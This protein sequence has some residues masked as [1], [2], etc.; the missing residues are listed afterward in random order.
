[1]VHSSLSS[2]GRVKGGARAV[3]EALQEAV[4][5][6]GTLMMPSFNHGA[7]YRPG[8]A[9]YYS[10]LETPTTNGAI[11]DA[12]W[13]MD[14][15]RR[16]LN[17]THAFAAWGR[18]A[19]R[20]TQHHHRTLTMGPGSPLGLLAS[21]GGYC[22]LMGVGYRANTFHHVV[23]MSTGAPCLG[24]RTE[25]YPVLL[26]D[27]RRVEG[28]TWGWRAG[29]CPITDEQRYA[30]LMEARGLERRHMV[31]G[32]ELILYRLWDCY[33]VVAGLLATGVDGFPSCSRC[34]VRPRVTEHTVPSDWDEDAGRPV[35]DSV[36]WTY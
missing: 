34:P 12:F 21:D 3:I 25:A 35:A 33:D 31:G 5:P 26:P 32:A 22:L 24:R 20:Y 11:P 9:G 10:P 14:G 1:M 30:P 28:R 27:G 13:R 19:E 18:H 23:E 6:E 15:V 36:A 29:R 8:A 16:S 4:G 17:P 7:A 2:F